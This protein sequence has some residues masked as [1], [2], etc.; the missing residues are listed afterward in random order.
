M[1]RYGYDN[2]RGAFHYLV[3]QWPGSVREKFQ[4]ARN[5]MS[6]MVRRGDMG[7]VRKFR[8]GF[9]LD[10]AKKVVRMWPLSIR[11]TDDD[12]CVPLHRAFSSLA[13]NNVM[14]RAR[15]SVVRFLL[16]QW[17]EAAQH[18]NKN[19]ELPLHRAVQA[20]RRVSLD[21]VRLLVDCTEPQ[22]SVTWRSFDVSSSSGPSRFKWRT[23]TGSFRC[24][25][26]C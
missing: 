4:S 10:C 17:P 6:A 23:T 9:S 1:L 26:R 18:P 7:A 2:H 22:F 12:G 3:D 21:E 19:G 14:M 16:E 15:E 13:S 5:L 25:R 11:A 20:R 8:R 24:T